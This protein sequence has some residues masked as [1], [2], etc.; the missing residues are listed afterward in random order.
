MTAQ[1]I[2]C[3]PNFSEG[4]RPEVVEAIVEAITAVNGITLLDR[5]SDAD[6]NRSVLTFVGPPAAVEEAAFRGIAK[7]AELID[8]E[9]HQGEHPRMGA[10]DVVPFVPISG[11]KMADCVAL[12]KRLGQRVGAELAIPVYLYEEAASKRLRRNL[13]NVRRGEYEGIR[14][15]IGSL[16]GRKPDFGPPALGKAGAVAI[17]ARQPLIAYNV[18]LNTSDVEVAK[19]IGKAV[20]HSSGGF[21][22]VKGAGFLVDGMAQ[23]SMNLTNYKQTPLA[24]VVETIRREATRYGASIVKTELV[25]LI[26]QQ[27][28]EDAAAWH[29]QLD[30]FD[31]QQVL[32]RRMQSAAGPGLDG[33]VDALASAAPAPGGGSAAAHA[34]ALAAALVAMVARLTISKKKY[35]DAEAQ[36]NQALNQAEV[37]RSAFTKAISEDAA[38]F[39]A[40]MAAFKLPQDDKG[41]QKAID[42]ATLE[43]ARQPLAVA[44]I[45][46]ECLRL[47]AQAAALGNTNTLSDAGTAGA[48]AGAALN[49]AGLNVRI[50]LHSLKATKETKAM[51]KEL[52]D[53]EAEAVTLQ[54]EIRTHIEARGGFETR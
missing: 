28:L 41:R 21:H 53:L 9:K 25:G 42:A 3:I 31:P 49:G 13:E 47:A 26:P 17:G 36:M 32:E 39:D 29:L 54:A 23:V 38:A 6:H 7:A 8:M 20:R 22:F 1:I 18:Y 16:P 35:A 4:R 48:L 51:L 52:Q 12:A 19:A 14:A 2:E 34:G 10:A 44:R 45:A 40:V 43:A 33:F 24:R 11:V 27:A 50:N 30:G 15:E 46:L 37:L 5:S